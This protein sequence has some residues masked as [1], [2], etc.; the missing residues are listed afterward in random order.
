MRR[1]TSCYKVAHSG[2]T[3]TGEGLAA[4]SMNK[5]ADL[6]QSAGHDKRESVVA[7]SSTRGNTAYD[8]DDVLDCSAHLNANDV[9][10]KVDSEFWC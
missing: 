10:G 6:G 7:E 8:G 3:H 4:A 2:K 5:T 1:C 9:S